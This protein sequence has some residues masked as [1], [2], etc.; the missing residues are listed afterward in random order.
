M[1]V[2]FSSSRVRLDIK[3]VSVVKSVRGFRRGFET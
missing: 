1:K 2:L 3:R